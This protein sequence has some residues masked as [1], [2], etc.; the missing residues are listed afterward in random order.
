MGIGESRLKIR[1]NWRGLNVQ[2]RR[3]KGSNGL[4]NEF[5]EDE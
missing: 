5:S 4:T 1:D 2:F 3:T